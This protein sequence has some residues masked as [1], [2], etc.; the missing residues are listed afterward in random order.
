MEEVI[1][2]IFTG[3]ISIGLALLGLILAANAR[4][5]GMSVFAYGLILFG[6][7]FVFAR[8]S[9]HFDRQEAEG[10]HHG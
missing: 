1:S 3:V 5:A 8:I 2:D 10:R 4:D 7:L 9:A 6:V